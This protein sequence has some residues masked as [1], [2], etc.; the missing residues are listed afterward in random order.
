MNYQEKLNYGQAMSTLADWNYTTVVRTH[1]KMKPHVADKKVRR[2]MHSRNVNAVFY[3]IEEDADAY[4]SNNCGINH[5]HIL[6]SCCSKPSREFLSKALEV[7]I[8][9][10]LN[11][12]EVKSSEDVS[13]YVTKRLD[14]PGSHHNFFF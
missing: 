9:A 10:V 7:N 14:T 4:Y 3:S 12:E 11:I 13:K 6:L 2:L 8:K 5:A 1:F